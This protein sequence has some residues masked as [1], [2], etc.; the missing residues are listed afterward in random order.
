MRDGSSTLNARTA[1][2]KTETMPN[3]SSIFSGRRILSDGEGWGHH[4]TFNDDSAGTDIHS[5]AGRYVPSMYDVVH[6][7]GGRV[8]FY[9]GKEKFAFFDRSWNAANGAVDTTGVDNGPD[10]IDR[11]V[12]SQDTKV[13]VDRAVRTLK[14]RPVKLTSL[15][16]RLPDSA[17]HRYG[18]GSEE[19]L[20]AVQQSSAYVGRVLRTIAR[21]DSLRSRTA[22]VLT[23]DHGGEGVSHQDTGLPIVYTVPFLVW[24]EGIARSADL[25]DLNP[26]RVDPG[27]GQ[28]DYFSGDPPVRNLDVA[29]LVTTYLGLGQVPGGTAPQTDPLQAW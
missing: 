9:A 23:A 11:Y 8:H 14:D 18:W 28:P 25:Y 1:I 21:S 17:G 20:A 26:Q 19:Y 15:H 5:V 27:S 12:Y 2:E 24:G 10:K 7:R 3:H 4:V 29:S 6:D 22:V 13:L 16:I